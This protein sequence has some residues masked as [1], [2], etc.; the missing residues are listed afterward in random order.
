VVDVFWRNGFAETSYDD[1]VDASGAS[2]RGLYTAFGDK[3]A[4]FAK[5]LA[6][7]RQCVVPELFA[8]L[9]DPDITVADIAAILRRFATLAATPA[10]RRGCLMAN[11]AASDM[12]FDPA[13]GQEV[14]RHLRQ[15]SERFAIALR[16]AGHRPAAAK[17]LAD[18][19]TG[20]LQGL[21]VLVR[22]NVS[23]AFIDNYLAVVSRQLEP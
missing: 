21:F 16:R 12:A 10:G 17:R 5:A 6:R 9:D 2:R 11:T 20:A 8:G 15:L 1:L 14:D 22:T 19:L 7:Y 4:L 18:Y 23:R 3:H 13:V